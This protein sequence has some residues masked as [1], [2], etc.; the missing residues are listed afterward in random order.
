MEPTAAT[1]EVGARRGGALAAWVAVVTVASSCAGSS[2]PLPADLRV[3][4]R[5]SAPAPSDLASPVAA[6]VGSAAEWAAVARS[7][8]LPA[9][10]M[11]ADA[12][13]FTIARC[14]LVAAPAKEVRLAWGTEEGVDVLTLVAEAGPAN[15]TVHAV[16]LARRPEPLTVVYQPVG[17]S[18]LVVWVDPGR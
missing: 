8:R 18:E 9:A 16:A 12:C 7:W 3:L 5:W 2:A 15:A 10:T 13:D 14:L 4:R 17:A 6:V 1:A 11:P